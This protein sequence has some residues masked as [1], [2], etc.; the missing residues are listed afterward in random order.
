MKTIITL[1]VLVALVFGSYFVFRY[2]KGEVEPPV[3]PSEMI[4]AGD[5]SVKGVYACLPHK[6]TVDVQTMEC[7]I[8][9]LAEDGN[10]Y[11]LDTSL[12]S[13]APLDFPTGTNVSVE[14]NVVPI[15]VLSTD[16]WRTYDVQ[17]IIRVSK[18]EKQ[19]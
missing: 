12:V 16:Q 18:I 7:A 17:G 3:S 15:E 4:K 6:E 8:G 5:F 10:N 2:K 14:G 1:V 9:L 11:A 13:A 19:N